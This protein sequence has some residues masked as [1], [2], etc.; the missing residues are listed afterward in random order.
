[1]PTSAPTSATSPA[2]CISRPMMPAQ[3]VGDA[4]PVWLRVEGRQLH[5]RAHPGRKLPLPGG[6]Q[7]SGRRVHGLRRLRSVHQRRDRRRLRA[8][9]RTAAA[10]PAQVALHADAQLSHA[11]S[12]RATSRPTSPT[13]MSAITP[14][15]S[16]GCSS[17]VRTRPGISASRR[18]SAR[19]GS[20]PCAA[21][22]C[23]TSSASP[24]AIRASSAWRPVPAACCWRV[25]SKGSEI[26]F[27][28]KYLW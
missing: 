11:H 28:A 3:P 14:R 21:R 10:A 7:L 27:Q 25:R 20:F 8:D 13:R 22:T 6:R 17:W 24:K 12:A 4:D 1:M 15:I 19:T 2:C 16:P 5:R 18:T 26:S 9:R 23:P